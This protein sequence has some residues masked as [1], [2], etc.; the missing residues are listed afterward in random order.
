MAIGQPSTE[1]HRAA[2]LPG[3]AE[4]LAAVL[5]WTVLQVRAVIEPECWL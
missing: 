2:L 3:E 4:M 1:V 5:A